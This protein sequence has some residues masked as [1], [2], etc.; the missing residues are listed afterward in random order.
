[1]KRILVG[2]D[3]SPGAEEALQDLA[4][5]GLPSVAEGKVLS[6]ADVWLPPEEQGAP[7]RKDKARQHAV[8][9]LTAARTSSKEGAEKLQGL[10]PKWKVQAVAHP[11]SPAWGILAEAR[12][13]NADLIVV[14]SHGRSMLERFFLG[15]V[16]Q[17][18]AAEAGCSVRIYRPHGQGKG[19]PRIL[20]AVDGSNDSA[21]AVEELL[22]REWPAETVIHAWT[23]LDPKL[24]SIPP[25]LF[26][27]QWQSP[28]DKGTEWVERMLQEQGEKLRKNGL[29][30]ETRVL[31]G[32]PKAVLLEQAEKEAVETIFLGA[33]GLQHGNRLYLGTLASAVATR[34][35]CSVEI[36]RPPAKG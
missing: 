6:I 1:M 36:V 29:K 28:G 35:H 25:G 11:E 12:K 14:G 4:R 19:A 10:F 34:A 8:E 27:E 32:E 33:R 16:S 20:I 23:V 26:H 5:A 24:R 22:S 7:E 18:V 15:S 17:K 31:E 21:A 9:A 13:W 2:Y 3:G 30:V